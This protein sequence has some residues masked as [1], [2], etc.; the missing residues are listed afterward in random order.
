MRLEKSERELSKAKQQLELS[1]TA[2]E[3]E[4]VR[5]VLAHPNWTRRYLRIDLHNNA[6]AAAAAPPSPPRWPRHVPGVDLANARCS[7]CLA[8]HAA[9]RH[10]E[11]EG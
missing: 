3:D 8:P 4:K 7:A 2:F 11:R 6:A 10:G 9:G 1:R 5:S